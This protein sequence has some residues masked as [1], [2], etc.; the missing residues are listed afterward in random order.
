MSG[1]DL[2]HHCQA[3]SRSLLVSGK[4][5]FENFFEILRRDA[6]AVVANLNRDLGIVFLADADLDFTADVNR[7][8][9]I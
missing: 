5:W 2:F 4:I 1:D 6:R 3:Q 8:Y 7:L 9:R